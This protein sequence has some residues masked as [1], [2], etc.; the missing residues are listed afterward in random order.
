MGSPCACR[1]NRFFRILPGRFAGGPLRVQ[2]KQDLARARGVPV[3][4]PPAHAWQKLPALADGVGPVAGWLATSPPR[5]DPCA[6]RAN[7]TYEAPIIGIRGGPLHV[8]GKP[9]G[10]GQEDARS[11]WT[12]ARAGQTLRR[13]WTSAEQ[14]GPLRVQGNPG[15]GK[16]N[17][18]TDRRTPARAGQT[19]GPMRVQGARAGVFATGGRS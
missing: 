19:R 15:V 10:L 8:Q 6:C 14:S 17:T 16:G 1:V 11:R 9:P 7:I 2:G 3:R 13:R 4:C 5:A 12:P 18:F